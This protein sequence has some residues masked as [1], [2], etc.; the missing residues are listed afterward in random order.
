MALRLAR[1]LRTPEDAQGSFAQLARRYAEEVAFVDWARDCARRRRR[2][3]RA[4]R[5]L[6]PDRPGRGRPPRRL[7]PGVRRGP[8]RLDRQ[9]LGPR[10]SSSASRTSRAGRVA[11]VAGRG[12][13]RP[14]DRARRH[15]LARRPRVAGRPAEAA[16]LGR[17]RALPAAPRR[18]ATAAGH[19]RD[20]QRDRVLP[21]E[22]A[23]RLPAPGPSRATRSGC[24]ASTRR[25]SSRS[26]GN[27]PPSSSTRAQLTQGGRG[28]LDAGRRAGDPPIAQPGRRGGDQRGGRP[29]GR[30]HAGP[31]RLDGR[32]DPAARCACSSVARESGRAVILA[33]DHGHVWHR[34]APSRRPPRPPAPDGGPADGPSPR[35][36]GPPRGRASAAAPATHTG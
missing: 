31:R 17:G 34:D 33:S 4:G 25:S 15:E 14:P 27:Y 11:T 3:A 13:A 28:A 18:A 5:R 12:A 26:S 29:A 19:R 16:P 35:R 30:G 21:D 22:P 2:P 23:G 7:Q 6:R 10:R 9:R 8:G 32:G 1:W 20:P 36:R 24:S